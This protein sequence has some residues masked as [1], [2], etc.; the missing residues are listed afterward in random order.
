MN[1][2]EKFS[3]FC[4]FIKI[5]DDNVEKISCRYK[6]ITKKLNKDFWWTDSETKHSLYVW[7]YWRDTDIYV[8]DVDILFQLPV[9]KFNQYSSYSWNWPSALLQEVKN[10]IKGRYWTTH[11]KW[12]WQIIWIDRT[13]WISFEIL[14]CFLYEEWGYIYPDTNNGWS[15]KIT[16]P[17]PE[18]QAINDMNKSCN[19]NLK[20]LCRMV[21]VWRDNVN[22]K[23]WW[24]LVDTFCYNFLKNW[25]YRD[26][27]YTYY[28]RMLRDFFG[29]LKDMDDNQ[30]YWLA[31]WSNQ[32]VIK[33]DNFTYKAKLTYNII[34]EALRASEN[35]QEYTENQKWKEIFW[36]IF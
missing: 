6:E 32:R 25:W 17:K 33:G 31:P 1:V 10:S 27:S 29:Y 15:R 12:D 16:N 28:D 4:E 2:S 35:K 19:Y 22:L 5:S 21:R 34:L 20:N 36:S 24:L 26:K 8:S 7:S 23:M 13:D 9:W 3:T 14:P 30:E 11:I 18:I